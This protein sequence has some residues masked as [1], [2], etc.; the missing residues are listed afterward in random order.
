MKKAAAKPTSSASIP[1]PTPK[2]TWPPL[3]S[4]PM[5][6]LEVKLPLETAVS[7]VVVGRGE[8]LV[9]VSEALEGF[10]VSELPLPPSTSWDTVTVAGAVA[11]LFEAVLD[12]T[13]VTV[14]VTHCCAP[15]P[16]TAGG[17]GVIVSSTVDSTVAVRNAV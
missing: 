15:E 2:P 6:V 4:S 12:A 11:A 10:G 13:A 17:L 9:V 7:A 3:L 5:G 1:T 8:L 14:T 16:S